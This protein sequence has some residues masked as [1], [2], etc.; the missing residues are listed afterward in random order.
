[1]DTTGDK[2]D[3]KKALKNF[4]KCVKTGGL[5]LIDHRNFDYILD[6]GETP[7]K[8]IYYNVSEWDDG[9]LSLWFLKLH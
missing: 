3:I 5:L 1:M 4:E 8:C 6:T 7:T 2:S 9:F